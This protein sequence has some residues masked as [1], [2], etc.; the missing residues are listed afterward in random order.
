MGRC[1]FVFPLKEMENQTKEII[2]KTV[3][4]L[5][6]KMGFLGEVTISDTEEENGIVCNINTETDSH[7]LIGQH[8]SNLQ[9]IQHLARLI[10][11]KQIP[12]K[13]RFI[14]DVNNYRQQKNQS[15]I[16]QAIQAAE[17]AI[18][19]H[20]SVSMK[21][22]STY[23]RRIAHMELSKNSKVATESIGE[24]EDRKIVVKPANL[25]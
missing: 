19:E 1:L 7:F 10:V 24:G 8:G 21:P 4:E 5:L 15:V 22:M 2:K 25:V 17:E 23:E 14:L 16:Q 9:A 18:S 3:D 13:I 11:R 20:R 6:E 12:D